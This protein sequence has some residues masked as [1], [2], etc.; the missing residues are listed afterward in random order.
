MR[1]R[2]GPDD[3]PHHARGPLPSSASTARKPARAR[4]S[5]SQV[6]T[7]TDALS[8]TSSPSPPQP[9]ATPS[10]PLGELLSSETV[11]K[12]ASSATISAACAPATRTSIR[13]LHPRALVD[14][15]QL[16]HAASAN[17]MN[18]RV[19]LATLTR[20]VL[21]NYPK[22]SSSD[23]PVDPSAPQLAYAPRTRTTCA[24]SSTNASPSNDTI[25][26][27]RLDDVAA[28]ETFYNKANISAGEGAKNSRARRE[29]RAARRT[30]TGSSDTRNEFPRRP[31]YRGR[32]ARVSERRRTRQGRQPKG[33]PSSPSAT[34]T[35]EHPNEARSRGRTRAR[36]I[37]ASASPVNAAPDVLGGESGRGRGAPDA[38]VAARRGGRLGVSTTSGTDGAT[39]Y[40]GKIRRRMRCVLWTTMMTRA[41][42]AASAAVSAAGTRP[43]LCCSRGGSRAGTCFAAARGRDA[44]RAGEDEDESAH[45]RA[46]AE[47]GRHRGAQ[48]EQHVHQLGVSTGGGSAER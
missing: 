42:A 31:T 11:Y 6:A 48:G 5:A 37:S 17:C 4:P 3:E 13:E 7:R 12:L 19:G 15:K 26:G 38:N 46:S 47:A 35:R 22:S 20:L 8:R 21:G 18:L 30:A 33:R 34:A 41:S 9:P 44:G 43:R 40:L 28:K 16:A 39:S 23:C 25:L 45:R 14:V 36:S 24:S 2:D 1:G 27:K 29:A 32:P 10:T